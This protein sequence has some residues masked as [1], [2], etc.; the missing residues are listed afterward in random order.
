[1]S[2]GQQCWRFPVRTSLECVDRRPRF[3]SQ[4]GGTAHVLTRL[5][6]VCHLANS[7]ARSHREGHAFGRARIVVDAVAPASSCKALQ[8]VAALISGR[9]TKAK[10][11][12]GGQMAWEGAPAGGPKLWISSAS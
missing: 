4:G 1:M 11:C 2:A 6:G 12:T 9:M 7:I 5:G 10:H 8:N 3:L